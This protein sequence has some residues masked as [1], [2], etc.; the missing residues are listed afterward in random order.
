MTS[1]GS[2]PVYV[3]VY[4]LT[5]YNDYL[6]WIGLGIYHSGIEVHGVE[7][8]YG[9]HDYPTSGVF[10][11]EPRNTP[12]FK[13]RTTVLLGKTLLSPREFRSYVENMSSEYFGDSYHLIIKNCN[14][15]S[16]DLSKRLVGRDIPGYINRL[17]RLGWF[18]NCLLPEALR[19][20]AVRTTP[21]Y[22]TFTE[23]NPG[24]EP[25]H[26][27]EDVRLL[28]APNSGVQAQTSERQRGD[29]KAPAKR[30]SVTSGSNNA[31]SSF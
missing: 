5:E 22:H 4:D 31:L 23:D 7:Y 11:V 16:A 25:I 28:S 24:D 12:G 17:A 13:Y 6:Y 8:A 29:A 14:H 9:A 10:E 18:F 3:N 30:S 2:T 19:V 21:E 26:A 15:F 27:S 1:S 20:D